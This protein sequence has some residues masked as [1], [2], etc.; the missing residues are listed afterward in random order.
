[1]N[2]RTFVGT[3]EDLHASATR[4]TGLSD[5]GDD[6]Y[7]EGLAVLLDSYAA[8]EQLTPAGSKVK[9]GELRGALAARLISEAAFKQHPSVDEVRIERPIFVTGLPRTGTT[10][11]HRLLCADASHQGLEQWLCEVPQPRPPR[12]TWA[13]DPIFAGI[14]AGFA[15]FHAENPEFAGVHYIAADMPEECWQ[16]LRQS[17]MSISYESL[18]HIPT[19]SRW[20]GEQDWT[21]AYE[22]HRRNLA[23]IGLNDLDKRWVLKNP[24]H[25]IALDALLAVYP[26]AIVVH[27]HRDPRAAVASAAS[28]S[29]LAT[30]GLSE[31]FVGEQI[32]RDS[33]D[34]LA[35]EAERFLAARFR[36]DP[37]QFLDVAY[38]DLLADPVGTVEGIYK[39]FDLPWTH[40]VR[41]AVEAEDRDSRTGR[42][43]P[44]H[45]YTL[46]D[47]GLSE[48]DVDA[49][50]GD[51]VAAYRR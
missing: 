32:G 50:L 11:V 20:L 26:D 23:L 5:Y 43:A 27:T 49:R 13:D 42:R 4:L 19:Y 28:L 41:A 29:E 8:D 15:R 18:A 16:L 30:R 38:E 14:Q 21:P 7:L 37:A 12:D 9:R 35:R 39:H 22:R 44:K 1:M 45:T 24:S 3:V 25:M 33:L 51:Y 2:D 47:F 34:L 17:L 10:A 6:G 31:R 40:E 46:A 36:H 48:A